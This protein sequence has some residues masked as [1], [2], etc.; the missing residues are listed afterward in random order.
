MPKKTSPAPVKLAVIGGSGLYQIP[1]IKDVKEVRVKTPF[2]DPS[3]A[4]IVGELS[5]VRCAF[6][7]RHGLPGT[8]SCPARS[9]SGPTCGRSSPWASSASW[10]W[11]P[12]AP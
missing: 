12:A 7:P 10:P 6:L 9:P 3:D 8:A 4:I 11:G 2:G 1:G 5:G